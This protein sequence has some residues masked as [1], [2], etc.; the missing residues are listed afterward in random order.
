MSLAYGVKSHLGGEIK[1]NMHLV[2]NFYFRQIS[3]IKILITVLFC[4]LLVPDMKIFFPAVVF[5]ILVFAEGHSQSD[6]F[7]LVKEEDG[8]LIYERW[9]TYPKTDPPVSAREVKGE[10][11]FHNTIEEAVRLLQDEKRISKW[12][13]H[14]SEFRVYKKEDSTKW[15]EY[16][17]HDI[18]WPVSDQDHLLAYLITRKENGEVFISFE[19]FVDNKLAPLQKGVTRMELS[20]SWT[21]KKVDNNKVKATYRIFSMPLPIPKF[22]TDPIIRNN[23]VTTIQEFKALLDPKP[24][25]K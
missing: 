14:V 13:S 6:D 23:M 11:Y 25:K 9:L 19:S 20:G 10:F 18:P 7:T 4:R 21:F 8:I 16:S 12:Q 17:Y 3:A 5:L 22:L 15:S 24:I 1:K 2:A